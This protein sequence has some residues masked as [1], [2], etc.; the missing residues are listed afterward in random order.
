MNQQIINTA[1]KVASIE[2]SDFQYALI[3]VENGRP[4]RKYACA[5]RR[6][7]MASSI[8]FLAKG[9]LLPARA[10]K[11][12]AANLVNA[13]TQFG[14][15]VPN[16]LRKEATR[17]VGGPDRDHNVVWKSDTDRY[18]LPYQTAQA[19]TFALE[20]RALCPLD[21]YEDITNTLRWYKDNGHALRPD[22]HREFATKVASRLV[23]IGMPIPDGIR[24]YAS[25][26]ASRE[27]LLE[28][29]AMRFENLHGN[30]PMQAALH[31]L[32]TAVVESPPSVQ[33]ELLMRFDK[34]AGLDT[35]W[36]RLNG[37]PDPVRS[38]FSM[39]KVA[40]APL[41]ET[42]G[43]MLYPE[44]LTKFTQHGE[45]RHLLAQIVSKDHVDELLEDPV[46]IFSSLPDP[47]KLAIARLVSDFHQKGI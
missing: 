7:A 15:P 4:M 28:S 21:T 35:V 17:Q 40:S 34:Q 31:K 29:L 12:A 23:K 1:E 47:H 24:E 20:K 46:A 44:E 3:L 19:R 25:K 22:E 16:R 41:L 38:V 27:R 13:L 11:V 9:G 32:A 42:G 36:N 43:V 6:S 14:A 45:A 5:D 30:E 26:N 33:V 8:V 10:R 39:E 37:V 2:A 18:E